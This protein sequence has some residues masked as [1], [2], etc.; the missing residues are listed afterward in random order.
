MSVKTFDLIQCVKLKNH[1]DIIQ[2]PN[3]SWRE[4]PFLLKLNEG[5][6][7]S[8]AHKAMRLPHLVKISE[9]SVY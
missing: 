9:G 8:V 7:P 1:N 4:K 3:H 6:I 2:K 5:K